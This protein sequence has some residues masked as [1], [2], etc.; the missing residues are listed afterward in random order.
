MTTFFF[1][2][3]NNNHR[4]DLE[5]FFKMSNW[6]IIIR[7]HMHIFLILNSVLLKKKKL[8]SLLCWQFNS[9]QM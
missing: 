8:I 6:G 3:K 7:G 2:G 5:F 9:I 1:C 4:S